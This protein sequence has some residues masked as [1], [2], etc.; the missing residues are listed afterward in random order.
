[1][2]KV[3]LFYYQIWDKNGI[4]HEIKTDSWNN[5]IRFVRKYKGTV[6]GFNQGS[7][8]VPKSRLQHCIDNVSIEDLM[9]L[10]KEEE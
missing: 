8:L 10:P 4:L 3:K 2:A 5:I 9:T 6:Q 1:M 7:R